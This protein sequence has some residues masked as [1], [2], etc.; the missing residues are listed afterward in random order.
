VSLVVV[1]AVGLEIRAGLHPGEMVLGRDGI[2]GLAVHTGA[3]TAALA[4]PSEVGRNS[5]IASALLNH[6]S[7]R[8]SPATLASEV[9]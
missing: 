7:T 8:V 1:R 9:P 6:W 3:R 5:H 2:G 4:G